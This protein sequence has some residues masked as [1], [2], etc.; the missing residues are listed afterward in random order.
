LGGSDDDRM[1]Q[2]LPPPLADKNRLKEH[3]VQS[4]HVLKSGGPHQLYQS[5]GRN[6]IVRVAHRLT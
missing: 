1:R 3:S 6:R 4:L 5:I 2:Q